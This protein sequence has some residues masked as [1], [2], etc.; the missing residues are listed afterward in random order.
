MDFIILLVTSLIALIN[1]IG[2][3]PT[4]LSIIEN[5]KNFQYEDKL[6]LVIVD[7]SKESSINKFIDIPDCLYLHLKEE[8]KE[9]FMK[10]IIEGY[11]QPNK[12]SL[13]YQKKRNRL[14]DGFKRDYGCGFSSYP[15]IFHM[16]ADCV[17]HP[18]T[19]ERKM[20]FMKRTSAECIYC[21][22]MLCYDIYGKELPNQN[23]APLRS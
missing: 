21:D 11:K 10:K 4:Y 16:N 12:S 7:D 20:R 22:K 5:F 19:I 8:E 17:Y 9:E 3:I 14:P 6:E 18:K 13:Y 23:G 15:Y 1:P 2:I